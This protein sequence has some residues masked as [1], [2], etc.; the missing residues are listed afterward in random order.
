MTNERA[1]ELQTLGEAMATP[2]W[3][4]KQV[5]ALLQCLE[6]DVADAVAAWL[7]KN[8]DDSAIA[9]AMA[10]RGYGIWPDDAIDGG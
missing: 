3:R 6:P 4:S 9:E 5:I 2:E 7:I 10:K 1:K 8:R